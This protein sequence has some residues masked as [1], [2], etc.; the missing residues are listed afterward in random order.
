MPILQEPSIA[1]EGVT[2]RA[3]TRS[4]LD[5]DVTIRVQNLNPVGVTLREIPFLLMIRED[6]YL[7]EIANGN[8]GTVSIP[9]RESPVL[10]VPV[11]SRNTDL[12]IVLAAFVSRGEVEVTIKGIAVVDAMITCWSVP[13]E[14]T[15]IVT[16]EQV[17]DAVA[18]KGSGPAKERDQ[19]DAGKTQ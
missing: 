6:G 12:V 8:T 10:T 17:A 5:L 9:A 14:R 13:F 1:L 7:Q 2:I 19:K 4:S 11:T 3:F 15:M 16:M 18:G